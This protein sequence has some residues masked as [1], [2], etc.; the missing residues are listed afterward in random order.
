MSRIF[1]GA[2]IVPRPAVESAVTHAR[3][4][5]GHEIVA[6]IVAL[7][8]RAPQVSRQRCTASPTQFRNP[9]A[10]TRRFLPAGSNTS[11]AAQSVSLPHALPRPRSDSQRAIA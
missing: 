9:L 6:E 2:Q 8:V 4:E 11:T 3:N 10:N 1:V 5:V 7:V